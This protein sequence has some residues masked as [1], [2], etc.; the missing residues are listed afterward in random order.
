MSTYSKI[1]ERVLLPGHNLVHGRQFVRHRGFLEQSQWWARERLV[2][3]QWQE[4]K[5]LLT[6]CYQSVP[7]YKKKYAEAGIG[8]N[9]IGNMDDFSRLPI[10]TRAEVNAHK[11]ELC[12]T[13]YKGKLLPHATGGSSGIPTRFFRTIESYDWRTAATERV[14]SWTGCRMGDKALYLWGAPVG[15]VSRKQL[16]KSKAH[17]LL[18]RHLVFNTFSQSEERWDEIFARAASFAP[19]L[20]VGYVSSL[21]EF[22]R[23][24]RAKGAVFPGVKAVIAAAEP[25]NELARGRISEGIGVPVFNTYGSREFMSIAGECEEHDG[26]H[27]NSENVL[28]ETSGRPEGGPSEILVTDLHNYG[29]PFLRYSIGDAGVL[30]NA[31]CRCGRGLPRL[32]TIDGR[33]LDLLQTATGQLVPGEFFPHLLKEVPEIAEYQVEQQNIYLIQVS[34]VLSAPLSEHSREF[35]EREFKK[36]IGESTNVEIKTVDRISKLP[37]GKKRAVIGL[38]K[39]PQEQR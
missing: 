8:L 24:L 1:L 6:H 2:E 7:Y 27:I 20:I 12:S 19:M 3:F 31:S 36:I 23:Y 35:L 29:M 39:V 32:K 33:L 14:Y 11:D 4:L 10:L 21:D 17:N 30:D 37:S 16:L 38:S 9:D 25:L 26:L 15:Q 5:A 18:L 34:A 22:A 13:A 28:V